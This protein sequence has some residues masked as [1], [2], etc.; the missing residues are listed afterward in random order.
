MTPCDGQYSATDLPAFV[1][2]AVVH[3]AD[4]N[5]VPFLDV[6]MTGD[7]GLAA[8][9]VERGADPVM[10]RHSARAGVL[11]IEFVTPRAHSN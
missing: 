10:S 3:G 1:E 5:A 11:I 4:T 7:R 8:F 2:L 6:L 9:F